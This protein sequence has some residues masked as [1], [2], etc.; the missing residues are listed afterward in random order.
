MPHTATHSK[1]IVMHVLILNFHSLQA[2]FIQKSL[3]YEN[4]GADLCYPENLFKVWYGQYEA[5]V[6]PLPHWNF[7]PLQ[8]LPYKLHLLGKTPIIFMSKVLPPRSFQSYFKAQKHI[9]FIST[10]HP[11]HQFIELLKTMTSSTQTLCKSRLT[12]EEIELNLLSRELKISGEP[13]V[14][15]HKEFALLE[16]FLQ[17]P[18][19]VLTRT[20]LL[21]N[22]WDR[23]TSILSN[24][25]DVHVSRLRNKIDKRVR[26]T[27]ILTIPCVGYKLICSSRSH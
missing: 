22:V 5:V 12:V 13:I 21:E 27:C 4:I 18:G 14:L 9:K 1:P 26:R 15:K 7:P 3:R 20:F 11:F 25:V 24:T 10:H 2:Q 8:E 17:H 6:L 19:Q 23:N 16:C